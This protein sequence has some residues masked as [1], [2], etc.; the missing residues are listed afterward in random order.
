MYYAN[1]GI[2][3]LKREIIKYIP[4]KSVF[5]ATDLIKTL[6]MNQ[7]KIIRFPLNGTW[8][9]IGTPQEYKKANELVKH[10]L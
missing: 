10:L 8:I 4:K 7:K 1:A 5:D 2:Y 6:I 9:D 3:L